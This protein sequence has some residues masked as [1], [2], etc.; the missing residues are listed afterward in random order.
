MANGIYK[1]TPLA[2]PTDSNWDR[3]TDQGEIIVRASSSGDA[4]V[5]ASE[6]EAAAAGKDPNIATTQVMASAFRDS[7][8]YSVQLIEGAEY[9]KDGPR[10]VLSGSFEGGP[11]GPRAADSI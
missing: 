11:S 2:G 5:V 3:A 1:L 4:R 9:P 6:A 7:H 8:L 10:E